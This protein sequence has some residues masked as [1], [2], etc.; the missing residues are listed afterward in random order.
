MNVLL[1]EFTRRVR[2]VSFVFVVSYLR[3]GHNGHDGYT[4]DTTSEL[5]TQDIHNS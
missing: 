5:N 4:T 1:I 2:C 3:F